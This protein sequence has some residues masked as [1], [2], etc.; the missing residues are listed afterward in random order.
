METKSG[1]GMNI[2]DNFS[3]SLE[4][5]FRV[6]NTEILLCGSGPGILLTMDPGRKKSDP[7]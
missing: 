4:T 3:E 7:V 6:K 2:S 1:F 5:V